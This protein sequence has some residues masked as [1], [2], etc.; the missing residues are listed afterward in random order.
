MSLVSLPLRPIFRTYGLG[1]AVP[2]APAEGDV[3]MTSRL[4]ARDG[5]KPPIVFN[6]GAGATARS[7]FA[8][9]NFTPGHIAL[10]YGL[11]A[12][13]GCPLIAHDNGGLPDKWANP[14]Q[15]SRIGAVGD[16]A[17]DPDELG[18]AGK[19]IEVGVS[20]GGLGSFNY[21]K[22]NPDEVA[23][24]VGVIP[25]SDLDDT[26]DNNRWGFAASIE[27]A[28][29]V[30]PTDP[31]PAGANPMTDP[32]G[33]GQIPVL[34]Y[35]AELDTIVIPATVRALN[36]LCGP[37]SLVKSCGQLEHS[38][39]AVSVAAADLDFIVDWLIS[40]GALEEAAP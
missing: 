2:S 7:S 18:A 12:R 32:G 28:W 20:M 25:L 29:G 37:G 10:A 11:A 27:A 35:V 40:V 30:G 9:V 39:A 1:R 8:N 13:T 19:V 23:A 16:Y 6:H 5:S 31:L 14:L 15:V 21:A 26:R 24:I 3:Q 38:E 22:A 17:R 4:W 36:A 33:L 34:A